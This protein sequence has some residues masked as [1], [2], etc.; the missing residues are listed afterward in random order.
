MSYSELKGKLAIVTGANNPRGIGAATAKAL[1]REGAS[2]FLHYFR[3]GKTAAEQGRPEPTEPGWPLYLEYGARSADQVLQEIRAAGG[4]VESW[5]ADLALAE[6]I[7]AL[8]DRAEQAFGPV[9]ILVNN[10]TICQADTLLPSGAEAWNKIPQLFEGGASDTVTAEGI[11]RHFAVN[12]R[13]TALLMAEFARRHIERAANWGRIINLSTTSKGFPGEISYGAS[14]HALE[15]YS[16]AAAKELGRFGI[17]VNI[18]I[19]GP[20]Q[21]GYINAE[22][23]KRS[24]S[25]TPLGR[26]GE[27]EDVGDVVLLLTSDEARWL[28]GQL[29]YAGGGRDM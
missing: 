10:H 27:P 23:A 8:F 12:T 29:L 25:E 21:S 20:T 19:P 24:I 18:V 1:A 17:T 7:P 4:K 26:L 3:V 11:D 22:L 9:Q 13:A 5:E 15:S 16:R 6:N 28:S 2:V 14:K